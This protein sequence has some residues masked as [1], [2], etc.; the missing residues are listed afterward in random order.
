MDTNEFIKQKE[1]LEKVLTEIEKYGYSNSCFAEYKKNLKLD[2][3]A[4]NLYITLSDT[5]N[6]EVDENIKINKHIHASLDEMRGITFVLE[7]QAS[8]D[9][10]RYVCDSCSEEF[11]FSDSLMKALLKPFDTDINYF[12]KTLH[13]IYYYRYENIDYNIDYMNKVLCR[14][15]TFLKSDS[16][17]YINPAIEAYIEGIIKTGKENQE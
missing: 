15:I 13:N 6:K 16:L 7:D 8:S 9:Y 5:W 4:M 10:Y 12:N 17:K 14:I 3:K 2:I 11:I 1:K